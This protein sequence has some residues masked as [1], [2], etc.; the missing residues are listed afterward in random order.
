MVSI[1]NL[2]DAGLFKFALSVRPYYNTVIYKKQPFWRKNN[3]FYCFFIFTVLSKAT[4]ARV[5]I[6]EG[7]NKLDKNIFLVTKNL[8]LTKK[9]VRINL[10]KTAKL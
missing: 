3:N 10:W 2:L 5:F 9:Y 1:K 7:F 8:Q 4:T 6:E